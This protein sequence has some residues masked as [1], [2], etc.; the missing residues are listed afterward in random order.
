MSGICPI[1]TKIAAAGF[2]LFLGSAGFSA[3]PPGAPGYT[4]P[5]GPQGFSN[6]L[7]IGGAAYTPSLNMLNRELE[8]AG[9][10]PMDTGSS[11]SIGWAMR[12][13]EM[14][15][16]MDITGSYLRGEST[17][18]TPTPDG[19]NFRLHII[20]FSTPFLY[21]H[22]VISEQLF[23]GGGLSINTNMVLLRY[24]PNS[25]TYYTASSASFNWG[26]VLSLEYYPF[27]GVPNFSLNLFAEKVMKLFVFSK[28]SIDFSKIPGYSP[29]D[30]LVT[31]DGD[32]LD[33][34][35]NGTRIG[36]SAN[37]YF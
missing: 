32:D 10:K 22:P 23:I 19:E 35:I 14:R 16:R 3:P 11:Y 18:I 15:L 25:D 31:S 6:G 5:P 8:I 30:R 2:L 1:R 21:E 28:P 26:P 24:E 13:R 12:D 20:T 33:F 27:P 36:F 7:S 17:A 4:A 37:L 9:M 29:G 34:E